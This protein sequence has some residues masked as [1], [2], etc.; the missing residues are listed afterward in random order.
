MLNPKTTNV[1]RLDKPS[2]IIRH[3]SPIPS[4]LAA[5]V[6]LLLLCGAGLASPSNVNPGIAPPNSNPHGKSYSEWAAAWWQWG[7]GIPTPENPLLDTTGAFAGVG[8]QGNVWFIGG[9]FNASGTAVR[10]VAIPEG[11]SLFF[12]ILN[13]TWIVAPGDPPH[14]IDY[15]RATYARPP[16]DNATLS[17]TIDGQAVQNL[18]GYREDSVV[19]NVTM[20]DDNVFGGAAAGVPGGVYGPCVDNGYYLMLNPLGRGQHT[21]HIQG[22]VADHSFTLDVTYHLTV[23][24]PYSFTKLRTLG[25]AIPGRPGISFMGDFEPSDINNNGQQTFI[26]DLSTGSEGVFRITDGQVVPIFL[27]GDTAPGGGTFGGFGSMGKAAL[28]HDGDVAVGFNLLPA[29]ATLGVNAGLFLYSSRANSLTALVTPFVTPA[30]GGGTFQGIN[31]SAAMNDDRTVAF[32]G[33]VQTAHGIHIPGQTYSGLGVGVF[34]AGHDGKITSVVSAGDPTPQGGSFDFFENPAINVYGD[35]AFDSHRAED[36][37]ISASDLFTGTTGIYLSK[38]DDY[39]L[40]T[41][42]RAG[43]MVPGGGD[44]YRVVFGPALNNSGQIAFIGDLASGAS[45][46][47]NEALVLYQGGHR[48]SSVARRGD[49]MPSGGR[50]VTT[51]FQPGNYDL[52]N[53]GIVAFGAALDTDD[54]HDGISDTGLYIWSEGKVSLIARTGTVIPG[55]GVIAHLRN[56]YSVPPGIPDFGANGGV[57]LNERGQIF[58][59][60]VLSDGRVVLLL[61]TP[62]P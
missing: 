44:T 21:I 28:N 25:D 33:V 10:Q 54:N 39:R 6:G 37:Q 47:E 14:T 46:G 58:F 42:A 40:M 49:L 32:A 18:Q 3:P 53:N 7:L 56:A 8:Q 59:G 22:E 9:V 62:N 55:V 12:P 11:T 5:L 48:Y 61:A 31:F 36:A 24:P 19:F 4:A 15:L 43:D 41:I 26:A 20:P 2:S 38:H 29:G 51:T 45:F 23:G 52:N 13:N 35:I 50:V 17:C 57:A 27:A 60:A 1:S 16:M 34:K 30:P